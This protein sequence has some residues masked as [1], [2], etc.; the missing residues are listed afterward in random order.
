MSEWYCPRK[1]LRTLLISHFDSVAEYSTYRCQGRN[2]HSHKSARK[3]CYTRTPAASARSPS[4][5]HIVVVPRRVVLVKH[6]ILV[7]VGP[8]P[9]ADG[10]RTR[11]CRL[12]R[13]ERSTGRPG[14][15]ASLALL[16]A[17]AHRGGGCCAAKP[18]GPIRIGARSAPPSGLGGR[19]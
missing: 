5:T 14:R 1:I 10:I 16:L 18:G 8:A 6:R 13:S 4:S 19:C 9:A 17:G 11:L 12:P 15:F 3:D 2:S 7:A